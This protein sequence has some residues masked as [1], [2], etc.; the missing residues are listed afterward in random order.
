MNGSRQRSPKTIEMTIMATVTVLLSNYNQAEY[1]RD[2]LRRICTQTRPADQIVVIDDGSTDD[3]L[4][5]MK[6]L[7]AQYP[8]VEVIENGTNLG[9]QRSIEIGLAR[10]TGDYLVWA[11]S[12]DRLLPQF[13]ERNMEVL[14]RHPEAGLAFSETSVLKGDTEEVD[15]FAINPLVK[16][17]FNLDDLPEYMDTD[18]LV[19]RM[20]RGYL[21]IASNTAVIRTDLVRAAGGFPKALEWHSDSFLACAIAY[22]FGACVIPETLQLIRAKPGTYSHAMHDPLRQSPVLR[23][24]LRLLRHHPHYRRIR[25]IYRACPSALSPFGMIMI[26]VLCRRPQDWDLLASFGLWSL[27]RYRIDHGFTWRQMGQLIGHRLFL[28]VA[29]RNS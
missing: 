27:Q 26:R 7:A 16:H 24:M 2:S 5:V 12:D 11:A 18:A 23:E 21:P 10:V 13:L 3:S 22:G 8:A 15:R 4:A 1:L 6:E 29:R 19:R 9:L 14:A 20:K 17:I 25:W 28:K